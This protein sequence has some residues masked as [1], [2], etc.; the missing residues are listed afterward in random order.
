MNIARKKL[1]EIIDQNSFKE[2]SKNI[3]TYNY[4]DFLN[5]DEKLDSARTKS[6]EVEA[7][8]IGTGS[9]ASIKCMFVIFEP[10]FIMGSMGLIAGEKI[11]RA[12]K[13]ATRWKLPV[14]SISASGGARMQEGVVS[15]IQMAKVSAAVYK[16]SMKKLL[17]I[18]IISDPTLG[19]ITASFA[20]LADIIIGEKGARYGFTGKRIIEETIREKLPDDFQT[21]E[22]AKKYGMVDI[23]VEKDE[24]KNILTYLVTLHYKRGGNHRFFKF[25]KHNTSS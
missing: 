14:I 8:I 5:Y 23:V 10:N 22:Y 9:I 20:S 25:Y 3:F 6:G 13:Y 21:V 1:L 16:H 17:N 15:L 24:L 2:Y 4:L 11:A 12:L 19:G 7:V 18:S